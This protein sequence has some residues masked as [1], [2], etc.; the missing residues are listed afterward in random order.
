MVPHRETLSIPMGRPSQNLGSIFHNQYNVNRTLPISIFESNPIPVARKMA[1]V[2]NYT[3]RNPYV[4]RVIRKMPGFQQ[5]IGS[6]IVDNPNSNGG[7]R[8]FGI[9]WG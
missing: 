6:P 7:I 9:R 4:N 8:L 5:G 2:A 3:K 1:P